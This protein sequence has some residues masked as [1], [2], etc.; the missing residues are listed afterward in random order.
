MKKLIL[1]LIPLFFVFLGVLNFNQDID[2]DNHLSNELEDINYIKTKAESELFDTNHNIIG[3]IGE[4]QTFEVESVNEKLLRLTNLP[5]YVNYDQVEP[6][7]DL[8]IPDTIDLDLSRYLAFEQMIDQGS[9]VDFYN[10]DYTFAFRLNN[11]P[12]NLYIYM[13]EEDRFYVNYLDSYFVVYQQ[14]VSLV[15]NPNALP[16]ITDIPVLMYHFFCNTA[17]EVGCTDNNWIEKDDF[18]DHM[19]YLSDH[20]FTSLK[21]VDI[22]RFLNSSVRLP[23]KSVS[24]TIDD[25]HQTVFD[26]AY[27]ILKE[28]DQIATLFI[29]THHQLDYDE[30][31]LSSYV[32]LHSHSH[33]MHRGHCD[34]GRGGLMQC[35]DFEKGVADLKQSSNLLDQ[36]TVYAY[37]FGDYND[38]AIAMLQEA[39]FSLA[40]TTESGRV[41]RNSSPL[42]LPRVRIST[43]TYSEQFK[44]LVN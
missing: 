28:F 27:P 20:D 24:I 13:Q 35:I 10:L 17:D 39:G 38:H 4:N 18:R 9:T 41:T 6:T 42:T 25:G 14:D 5:F 2:E 40:F 29:I 21:M 15:H 1:I 16:E 30:L 37:P 23:E 44:Y 34:A 11:I 22:E 32:E 12:E 31:L 7:T 43:S 26:Y 8:I 33:D 3:I 19:Q 36:S